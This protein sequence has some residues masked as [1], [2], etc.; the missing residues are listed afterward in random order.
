MIVT[1]YGK[2]GCC[3]CDEA[4][5]ALEEVAAGITFELREVDIL[6]DPRLFE[7]YRYRIPV[8]MVDGREVAEGRI[9]ALELA[10]A[11]TE[12]H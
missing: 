5:D 11:L 2:V 12:R 3:L 4:R 1:L 6:S 8:V 7:Q 9:S 10:S